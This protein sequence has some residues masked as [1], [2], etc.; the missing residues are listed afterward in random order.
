MVIVRNLMLA[1]LFWKALR[2]AT[3]RDGVYQGRMNVILDY[4][5]VGCFRVRSRPSIPSCPDLLHKW[6]RGNEVKYF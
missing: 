1:K 2:C 5:E 3:H 6:G 4:L